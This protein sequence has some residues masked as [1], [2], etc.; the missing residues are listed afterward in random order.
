M[1][2]ANVEFGLEFCVK[3]CFTNIACS[4]RKSLPVPSGMFFVL[5]YFL[6]FKGQSALNSL[7]LCVTTLSEADGK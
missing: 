6:E 1:V 4:V 5:L 3:L 2:P 7:I